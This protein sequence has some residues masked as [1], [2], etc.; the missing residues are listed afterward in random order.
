MKEIGGGALVPG[1][2][3]L[4]SSPNYDPLFRTAQNMYILEFINFFSR[5]LCIHIYA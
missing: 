2:L 1:T 5:A 3:V 4:F